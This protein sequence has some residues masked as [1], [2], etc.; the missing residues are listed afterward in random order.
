MSL[1]WDSVYRMIKIRKTN[2]CSV[3]HITKEIKTMK[4]ELI[5]LIT[6]LLA[7]TDIDLLDLIYKIL[8]DS[9]QL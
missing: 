1:L 2:R 7:N 9:L 8:S 6:E 3:E 5:A 4:E